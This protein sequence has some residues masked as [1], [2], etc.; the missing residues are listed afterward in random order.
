M[1]EKEVKFVPEPGTCLPWEVKLAEFGEL[2][3]NEAIVKQ[4]WE[5]LDAF[6]YSFIWWFVQR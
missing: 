5:K 6:A 3:G 2:A 1:A 4:E